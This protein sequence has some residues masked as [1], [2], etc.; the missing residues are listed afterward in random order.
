MNNYL[1]IQMCLHFI[2]SDNDKEF[3]NQFMDIVPQQ[4]V[5][6]HIFSVP[7][8]PQSNGKLEVFSQLP[9]TYS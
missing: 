7:Y 1:P 8:H 9:E 4:R 2:L 5:I 3:K 6:D